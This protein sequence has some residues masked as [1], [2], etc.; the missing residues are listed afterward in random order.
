MEKYYEMYY[1][2]KGALYGWLDNHWE[3]I[4]SH[5]QKF[6]MELDV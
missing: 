2:E 3:L 4:D 1:L 5:W 6:N